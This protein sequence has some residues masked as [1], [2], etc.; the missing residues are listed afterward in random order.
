MSKDKQAR[1]VSFLLV[2]VGVILFVLNLILHWEYNIALP[3]LFLVLGGGFFLV[4][5]QIRDKW[6]WAV[7][8]YI[9]GLLMATFGIIFF[10]NV[11]TADWKSWAYAWLLLLAAIGIGLLLA[12]RA[13][14]KS[15]L[16]NLIGWSLSIAGITFFAIFG[17]V[18]GGLF[19]EVIAPVFIVGIGLLIYWLKPN[20]RSI[21]FHSREQISYAKVS[22]TARLL[23]IDTFL[24]EPLSVREI[25]VLNLINCGFSNAQIASKLTVAQ[26]T[27]KTHINNIYGKL[28]VQTR[29]QAINKA[30][31]LNLLDN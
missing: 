14:K 26:S 5:E 21:T 16:L 20:F 7:Y 3:L 1:I 31:A 9:P 23:D 27:V 2:G 6:E 8:L 17:A 24:A 10:L 25:E 29:V 13:F 30:R 4:T 28:G 12:N 18:A 19:I 11:L 15:S 22:G